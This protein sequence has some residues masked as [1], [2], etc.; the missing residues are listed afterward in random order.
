MADKGSRLSGPMVLVASLGSGGGKRS[1]GLAGNVAERVRSAVALDGNGF[2][3]AME[4]AGELISAAAVA[5]AIL[6]RL[7]SESHSNGDGS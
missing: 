3:G 2:P 7:R 6:A 4:R 1:R 5:V